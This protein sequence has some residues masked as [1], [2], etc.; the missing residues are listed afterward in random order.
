MSQINVTQEWRV[1]SLENKSRHNY[2][3]GFHNLH[4]LKTDMHV[5]VGISRYMNSSFVEFCDSL[6]LL[7][8]V[9]MCP[10]CA[11]KWINPAT[12]LL[13]VATEGGFIFSYLSWFWSSFPAQPHSHVGFS[14][15][16][17]NM[18]A[19]GSLETGIFLFSRKSSFLKVFLLKMCLN[20]PKSQCFDN[21]LCRGWR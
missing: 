19:L 4:L 16:L 2:V 15:R 10:I 13:T 6:W 21:L 9:I 14:F 20:G 8:W 5:K 18:S 1:T 12:R 11:C 7:K 17:A 3:H